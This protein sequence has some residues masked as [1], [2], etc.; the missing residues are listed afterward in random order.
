MSEPL[1]LARPYA[2]AAFALARDRSA[3][4]NWSSALDFAAQASVQPSV[5]AILGHPALTVDALVALL[6]PDGADPLF[7]SFLRT[8]AENRRLILLPEIA[9]LYAALRAES[10]RIVKAQVV[11]A[12]PTDADQ[13]AR[14][15]DGLRRRF[16]RE[17]EIET[18]I[19]PDLIGGVLVRAGDVVIDGSLRSKL[20]RLRTALV[21]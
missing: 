1:T 14:I 8:L 18:S 5:R 9:E 19:D 12:A 20:V 3:L 10:E 17:V 6:A 4:P 11:T 7:Q 2:R 16:G 21:Q 13:L 15:R